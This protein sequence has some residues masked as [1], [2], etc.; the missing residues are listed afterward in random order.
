MNHRHVTNIGNT[1]VAHNT[2]WL[3]NHTFPWRSQG[4]TLSM[5]RDCYP[6]L[7]GEHTWK[8]SSSSLPNTESAANLQAGATINQSTWAPLPS[9]GVPR[10][11]GAVG[12][13]KALATAKINPSWHFVPSF[14]SSRITERSASWLKTSE[15]PQ[16]A[17]PYDRDGAAS[18]IYALQRQILLPALRQRKRTLKWVW[19]FVLPE[20]K[21][22]SGLTA[23]KQHSRPAQQCRTRGDGCPTEITGI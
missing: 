9:A 17:A 8:F 18:W 23:F 21:W 12:G 6:K 16:H 10:Q 15:I 5:L 2:T 3:I 7:E 19:R 13:A 20:C 1:S 14:S 22:E 11:T 4:Q